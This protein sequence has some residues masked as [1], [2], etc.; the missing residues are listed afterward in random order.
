MCVPY[1]KQACKEAGVKLGMYF[2]QGNYATK[3]C[4]AYYEGT[5]KGNIWY[6]KGGTDAQIKQPLEHNP[7]KK[8]RPPWF[9]CAGKMRKIYV[10]MYFLYF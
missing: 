10:L 8:Y 5:Y 7:Y 2:H 9:D 3:G 4:Y 6:G 1:S